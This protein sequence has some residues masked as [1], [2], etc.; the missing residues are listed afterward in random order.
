M[1]TFEG[2]VALVTGG[3]SGIGAAICRQLAASG[4]SVVVTDL[5]IEAANSVAEQ[6]NGESGRASAF[7]YDTTS[8]EQAQK[9]IQHAQDTFG[10]LH[11]AVNNAGIAPEQKP[12]GEVDL[13]DWNKVIAVNLN[14]V[15]YGM[16]YQLPAIEKSGEGRL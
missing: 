5:R 9:S 11:L 8:A 16:R 2:K 6:I 1:P 3:G 14:G 7:A 13:D 12:M 4:A 10:A 15:A